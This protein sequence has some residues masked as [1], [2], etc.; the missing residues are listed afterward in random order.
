MKMFCRFKIGFIAITLLSASIASAEHVLFYI[1]SDAN[2]KPRPISSPVHK[3]S[4]D[5]SLRVHVTTYYESTFQTDFYFIP[6]SSA[7]KEVSTYGGFQ[8]KDVVCLKV[9][10]SGGRAGK[11]V[12][13]QHLYPDGMAEVHFGDFFGQRV[14]IFRRSEVLHISQLQDCNLNSK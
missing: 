8:R 13:I 5:G 12:E 2:L 3:V 1:S 6:E 14:S 10:T 11:D 7:L 4:A 9:N